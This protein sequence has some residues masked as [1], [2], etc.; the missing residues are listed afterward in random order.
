MDEVD[1]E[2]SAA[3]VRGM[4]GEGPMNEA[5][6]V[7]VEYREVQDLT[8]L[9]TEELAQ[10]ANT[11]YRQAESVAAVSLQLVAEAGK[12]LLV[13]KEKVAHGEGDDWMKNNLSFSGRKA[14]RMMKLADKME[15]EGSFFAN[16]TTL[17]DI[18]ISKVWALLE[19]PEEA[20]AEVMAGSDVESMTV[21]ELKAEIEKIKSERAAVE[22]LSQEEQAELIDLREKVERQ[23]GVIRKLEEDIEEA[24]STEDLEEQ[25]EAAKR[26]LQNT[27]EKLKHEKEKAREEAE[28]ARRKALAEADRKIEEARAAAEKASGEK[29]QKVRDEEAAKRADLEAENEKLK[30]LAD[31]V[32]TEFK[33]KVDAFQQSFA[34]CMKPIGEAPDEMADK[35]RQALKVVMERMEEQI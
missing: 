20:V 24:G 3:D 35:M 34:S 7:D 11:I 9:S 17:S 8:D 29:L 21:K 19:A 12:R 23:A 2:E 25:L 26:N 27:K 32:M 13:A 14:N 31:P 30:K 28:E 22:A 10:Q 33:V 4:K 6:I 16:P 5:N 1:E 15:E 18:G